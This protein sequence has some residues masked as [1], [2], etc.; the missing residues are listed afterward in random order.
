MN[1]KKKDPG[2]PSNLPFREELFQHVEH[3]K[4]VTSE[5]RLYNL[6]YGVRGQNDDSASDRVRPVSSTRD[7]EAVINE[8]DVILEVL[9][10]RDPQGTRNPDIESKV[11]SS[12]KRLVLVLNKIDLIPR[13]NLQLWLLYL[14][15]KFTVLPFKAS[16]QH[17]KRNLS[18]AKLPW[19]PAHSLK[20]ATQGSRG[21]GVDEL[22]SLLANYT[23]TY[24]ST[25]E[26]RLGLTVGVIGYPNTGKS[27]IV[28]TLKRRKV[29]ASSNVPGLTKRLQRVKLDKNIFL[30]DSPGVFVLKQADKSDLALKNCLKPELLPDPIPVI[31]AILARCPKEQLMSK[32]DIQDYSD[33]RTFLVQIAHRLGRLKKGGVPNTTLA[34]RSII[35][36][37]I[38][39][40]ILY[41]TEPPP[42]TV[43]EDSPSS[44]TSLPMETMESIEERMIA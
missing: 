21:L 14:R 9:D 10:A 29:C 30:L 27:A 31:E 28:N 1:K 20:T 39:G 12:G 18:R 19:N 4:T 38:T 7:A 36:D 34:A 24:N 16:L 23:R 2:V 42:V 8:S 5:V 33:A 35:N 15:R 22:M 6:K 26:N 40:K 13:A 32:Y 43:E 17:Q 41:F 44:N 11:L 25:Q 3:L 37:W